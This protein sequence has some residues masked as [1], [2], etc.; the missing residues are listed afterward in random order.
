MATRRR[1]ST[2][3]RSGLVVL[4]VVVLG[5]AVWLRLPSG[6]DGSVPAEDATRAM[7]LTAVAD[8]ETVVGQHKVTP[9]QVAEQAP[10]APPHIEPPVSYDKGLAL[11]ADARRVDAGGDVLQARELYSRALSAGLPRIDCVET[12]ARLRQIAQ[13]TVLNRM[14]VAGDPLV[15]TYTVQSGD[16]LSRVAREYR[17]TPELIA[18][19]NGLQNVN[20]IRVGQKLAVPNGP[21]RAEIIKSTHEMYVYLGD[22][23]VEYFVV[24]LGADGRTPTGEW[25]ITVKQVNPQYYPPNGGEIIAPD[26]PLNPLGE[27]W[28][29]FEGV[30]GGAVG[31]EGFGIHGTIEP[32]TI[33]QDASLGCVRMAS[34]D[35]ELVYDLLISKHSPVVIKE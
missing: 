21:F 35:V 19:I 16:N 23:L 15:S 1:R 5:T 26:D 13:K 24:G 3:W 25:V 11:L 32:E 2:H 10:P 12:R 9:P 7:Q 20:S 4:G 28:M 34:D 31:R 33:G 18:R 27:R 6:S 29:G 22:T 14:P 30:G 17:V 8:E